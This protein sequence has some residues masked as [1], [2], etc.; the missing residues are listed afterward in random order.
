VQLERS[1]VVEGVA[2]FENRILELLP[3]LYAAALRM[4]H[5]RADAEDLVAD[6][7]SKAWE[8]RVS[9]RDSA[10]FRGWL[11]KILTNTFITNVRARSARP[12]TESLDAEESF[13]L[14]ERLHQPFLMWWGNAEEEF[15]NRLLRTDLEK[16]IDALPPEFRI[17]VLLVDVEGFSYQETAEVLAVP[18]G[19]V[20]SRLARARSALQKALWKHAQDAG[21]QT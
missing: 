11:F 8:R 3:D 12:Q 2:D 19:T 20:R 7:V 9:L 21:Y 4:M 6:T 18:I 1:P 16:A 17:T 13:S 15:L 14:F 10:S 5:N